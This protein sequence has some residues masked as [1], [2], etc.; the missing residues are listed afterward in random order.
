[1]YNNIFFFSHHSYSLSF[2]IDTTT[3]QK[4]HSIPTDT[5]IQQKKNKRKGKHLTTNPTP[6]N[7]HHCNPFQ[8]LMIH[9]KI[10]QKSTKNQT[11]PSEKPTQNQAKPIGLG[12]VFVVGS[13]LMLPP[14]ICLAATW[15]YLLPPPDLL[16]CVSFRF[17]IWERKWGREY[18]T[19]WFETWERKRVE[20]VLE[21]EKNWE[22]ERETVETRLRWKRY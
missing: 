9:H 12:I 20:G 16:S 19:C 4:K 1:M 21:A 18:Q 15:I 14:R 2:P 10:D 6:P 11:K 5:T 3:Q 17:D 7:H 13:V 22:R 8:Q